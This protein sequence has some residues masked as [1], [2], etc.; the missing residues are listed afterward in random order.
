MKKLGLKNP[1]LLER[2][3]HG[4]KQP[5]GIAFFK[6][7]SQL[8]S[9]PHAIKMQVDEVIKLEMFTSMLVWA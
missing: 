3:R 4:G 2:E 1:I 5:L 7:P 9:E 8:I 6:N